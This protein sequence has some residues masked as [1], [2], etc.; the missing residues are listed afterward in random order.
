MTEAQVTSDPQR[1]RRVLALTALLFVALQLAV[2]LVLDG[3]PL[4]VRFHEASTAL[5]TVRALGPNPDVLVFGSSRFKALL[6]PGQVEARLRETLG[7]D[8]PR[9]TSLAFNGGDLVGSDILFGRV[10]DAGV[11]PKLAIIELTPEWVR[12]PVPFLNGQ[13]LRAFTWRDVAEWLPELARGTRTTLACARLFPIYCYRNELLTWMVGTSPPYLAAPV[14]ENAPPPRA[15]LDDPKHGA[16]RWTRRMRGY[17]V[18]P[19]ALSLIDRILDRCSAAQIECVFVES[20]VT[21]THR[22]LLEG[23]IDDSFRAALATV[24]A[25]RTVEF[26]DFSDRIPDDGFRDS[27]HGN[28]LGG[29]RFSAIVADEVIAP[30]WR[31]R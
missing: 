23:H 27:S 5:D 28:R 7:A 8:A 16:H 21:S 13:L 14:S 26:L 18:S 1:A 29:E 17:R 20:P 2:G 24:Q 12:F 31:A 10:V 22:E 3:A 4:H 9:V 19:R 11:H 15:K 30:R 6:H 25:R